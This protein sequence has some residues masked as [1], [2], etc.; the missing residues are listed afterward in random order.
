MTP[1]PN[2]IPSNGS[3]GG[4]VICIQETRLE[5]MERNQRIAGRRGLRTELAQKAMADDV[6]QIKS[7]LSGKAIMGQVLV[8]VQIIASLA[9]V[10]VV[11]SAHLH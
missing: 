6:T 7:S 1:D 9:A 3:N 10:Y 4:H 11:L 2:D 5:R 8:I